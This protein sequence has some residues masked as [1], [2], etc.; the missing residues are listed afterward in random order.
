[1]V[2]PIKDTRA[3]IRNK[4]KN[5]PI[6]YPDL[7]LA[8]REKSDPLVIPAAW[9]PMDELMHAMINHEIDHGD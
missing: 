2:S 5:V 1:M 6:K 8:Y 4:H 7:F 9:L 3:P